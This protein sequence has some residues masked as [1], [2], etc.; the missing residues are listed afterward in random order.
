MKNSSIKLEFN[1]DELL[2][3]KLFH[4]KCTVNTYSIE[5][6][7]VKKLKKSHFGNG[8]KGLFIAL[9]CLMFVISLAALLYFPITEKFMHVAYSNIP[10]KVTF[11]YAIVMFLVG[12]IF[13]LQIADHIPFILAKVLNIIQGVIFTG[14]TFYFSITRKWECFSVFHLLAFLGFMLLLLILVEVLNRSDEGVNQYKNYVLLNVN[15]FMLMGFVFNE[16]FYT[17]RIAHPD[18]TGGKLQGIMWIVF[19]GIVVLYYI[20]YFIFKFR[21]KEKEE[22]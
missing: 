19:A 7:K 15:S 9:Y 18:Y 16:V 17:L 21:C 1:K 13:P 14:V 10:M 11:Y 12:C 20:G 2:L 8:M 6:Q 5:I 22:I 3:K 4:S